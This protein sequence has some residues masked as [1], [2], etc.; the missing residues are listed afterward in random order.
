MLNA[1]SITLK[2]G[3]VLN[4]TRYASQLIKK[5]TVQGIGHIS[6]HSRT[7]NILGEGSGT[8]GGG[9][10]SVFVRY[11]KSFLVSDSC[12]LSPFL[13]ATQKF[14]F[15]RIQNRSLDEIVHRTLVYP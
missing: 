11:T 14:D 6:G 10:P 12:A 4:I 3:T 5:D 8:G 7:F 9:Q 15:S 2:D 1:E 13:A